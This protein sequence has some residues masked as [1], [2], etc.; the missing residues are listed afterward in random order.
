MPCEPPEVKQ[1]EPSAE[2]ESLGPGWNHVVRGG[3]VIR[4]RAPPSPKPAPGQVTEEPTRQQVTPTRAKGKAPKSA[5]K[6][7]VGPKQV[8]VT[9]IS[10]PAKPNQTSQLQSKEL[11]APTKPT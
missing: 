2:Q 8:P 7:T 10:K 11:V 6:V 9:K 4:A 1:V 5:P 3:R